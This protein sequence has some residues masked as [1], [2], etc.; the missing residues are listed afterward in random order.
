M[1]LYQVLLNLISKYYTETR[2][3]NVGDFSPIHNIGWNCV[4]WVYIVLISTQ[5]HAPKIGTEH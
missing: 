1:L 2:D 4:I 3:V 5:K